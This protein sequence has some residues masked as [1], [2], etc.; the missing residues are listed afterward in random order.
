VRGQA[1]GLHGTGLMTFQGIGAG[2]AAVLA[3]V[4]PVPD[5]IG[6][7]AVLSLL[8][9]AVLTPGLRAAARA[10]THAEVARV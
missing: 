3:Q 1:L 10:A 2:I 6:N 7:M 5:A 4:V 9:S 8:V